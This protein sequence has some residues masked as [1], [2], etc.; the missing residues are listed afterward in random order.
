MRTAMSKIKTVKLKDEY[1]NTTFENL[2]ETLDMVVPDE[3]ERRDLCLDLTLY[4]NKQ[5]HMFGEPEDVD[6][7]FYLETAAEH[8]VSIAESDESDMKLHKIPTLKELLDRSIEI[9]V[10]EQEDARLYEE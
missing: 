4:T 3:K 5:K 9:I 2:M 8:I 7:I 10:E 6:H 1:M